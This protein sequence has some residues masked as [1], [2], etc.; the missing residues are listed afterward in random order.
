MVF[1]NTSCL[2]DFDRFESNEQL[3]RVYTASDLPRGLQVDA[4]TGIL[5]G[6]VVLG[7]G[8]EQSVASIK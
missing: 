6:T 2:D 5:S 7:E 3:C 8:T 4:V 1:G